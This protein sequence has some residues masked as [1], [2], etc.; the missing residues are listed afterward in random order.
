MRI[1]GISITV[2]VSII[3]LAGV[4][5]PVLTDVTTTE[6]TFKNVGYYNLTY[7]ESESATFEWDY[8]YP[9]VLTVNG[10]SITLPEPSSADRTIICGDTFIVG[11]SANSNGERLRFYDA[12][13]AL[14][15]NVSGSSVL[16]LSCESGS[17]SVTVGTTT[18]EG[19][20]T[21]LFFIDTGGAYVLKESDSPAYVNGDS[22]ITLM[23][24]T[25][26]G[27]ATVGIRIVGTIDDGLTFDTFRGEDLT[28]SNEKVESS[29]DADFKDLYTVD[30]LSFTISD[31]TN[32]K[33]KEFT[34]YI[35]PAEVTA[36]KAVHLSDNQ[37][38][39]MDAIPVLVVIAI[40]MGVVAVILARRMD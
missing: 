18:Y 40:L 31:G 38:A 14:T 20:Y 28:F 11:Y 19:T 8:Q 25:S 12:E 9:R 39:L 34:A 21:E 3:V 35:V 24:W 26:V 16:S 36:E 1:V 4:L 6:E 27:A 13:H 5:M 7:T 29:K 17:Y 10:D 33:N 23:D 32:T 15:A 22:K 37:I 2:V 30:G